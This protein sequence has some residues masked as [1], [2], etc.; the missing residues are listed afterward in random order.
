MLQD[1]ISVRVIGKSTCKTL[2][3]VRKKF[4]RL[5]LR[6]SSPANSAHYYFYV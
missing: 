6:S 5:E 3:C 2:D 4:A 1:D